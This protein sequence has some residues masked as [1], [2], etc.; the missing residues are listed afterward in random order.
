MRQ[1]ALHAADGHR[2]DQSLQQAANRAGQAYIH[3]RDSQLDV[4]VGS[5]LREI[6]VVDAHDFAAVRVDDLLVEQILA[7]GEPRL[8]RLVELERRLVGGEL[9]AAGRD[10]GDLVV[11]RDERAVL[12]AAEQQPRDA[13]GLLVG[14]DEH[15]LHAADKVPGGIVGFGAQNFRGV[16]HRWLLGGL[17]G[18]SGQKKCPGPAVLPATGRTRSCLALVQAGP[19]LPVPARPRAGRVG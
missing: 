3:L 18:E 1:L 15:L 8:V 7:D 11:A 6:N 16:Q 2:R 12:P 10:F 9:H 5:V 17:A 4:A 19:R 14:H 13:V